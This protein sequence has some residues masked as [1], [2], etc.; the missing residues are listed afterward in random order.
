MPL[1]IV[2][3]VAFHSPATIEV[4]PICA[5]KVSGVIDDDRPLTFEK[6]INIKVSLDINGIAQKACEC[7]TGKIF[8]TMLRKMPD[9]IAVGSSRLGVHLKH[10]F[11]LFRFFGI[12]H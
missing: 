11:D 2:F 1:Q 5:R 12:C 4:A 9:N 7:R 6:L 8:N 3:G 10:Q